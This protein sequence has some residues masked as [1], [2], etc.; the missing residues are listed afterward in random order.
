MRDPKPEPRVKDPAALRRFRLEHVGE[1]CERCEVRTGIHAHHRKFRSQ[2]GADAE[3]NLDW[4]CGPCHD[5][6][7]GIRS[8]W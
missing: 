4:L 5:E 2:G 7:H 8:V 3:S 6:V 1:P